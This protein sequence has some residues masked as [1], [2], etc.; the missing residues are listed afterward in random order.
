MLRN[1]Y[2]CL[3][4]NKVYYPGWKCRFYV[5]AD[6]IQPVRA[7]LVAQGAE[8]REIPTGEGYASGM[9]WRFMI[10]VDPEVDRYIIRDV[11]SRLNS[12]DR[13]IFMSLI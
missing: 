6:V 13:Y 3:G 8:L 1:V 10:A 9:F 7:E 5:T 11:D 12:R 4:E 2:L